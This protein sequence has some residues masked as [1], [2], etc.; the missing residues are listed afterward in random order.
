M[1]LF[2]DKYGNTGPIILLLQMDIE[3]QIQ[4]NSLLRT[5]EQNENDP[6]HQLNELQNSGML[7]VFPDVIEVQPRVQN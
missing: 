7:Q 6:D 5:S 3:P 2:S 4:S 1:Y